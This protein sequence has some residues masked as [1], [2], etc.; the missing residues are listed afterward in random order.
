MMKGWAILILGSVF[1]IGCTAD[2]VESGPTNNS[3]K[4]ANENHSAQNDG[5]WEFSAYLAN[6]L[7]KALGKDPQNATEEE[8]YKVLDDESLREQYLNELYDLLEL[9]VEEGLIST[10]EADA[11]KET[12]E[13]IFEEK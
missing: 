5:E 10:E 11:Q 8:L 7:E 13:F 9:K 2:S 6:K 4:E 12:M 1:L 3:N